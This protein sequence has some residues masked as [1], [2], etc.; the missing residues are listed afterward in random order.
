MDAFLQKRK[1][2]FRKFRLRNKQIVEDY[3]AGLE[4]D[5]NRAP[6]R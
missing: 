3:L 1:P 4:A 2:D 5:Q 6:G